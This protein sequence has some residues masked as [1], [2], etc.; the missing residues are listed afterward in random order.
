MYFE[1]G[2]TH[3]GI[4]L[5]KASLN[6]AKYYIG[7]TEV[8]TIG[9]RAGEWAAAPVVQRHPVPIDI[10]LATLNAGTP[11][12]VNVAFDLPAMFIGNATIKKN[13]T[14]PL[15]EGV[16]YSIDRIWGR[17]VPL[18]GGQ[19]DGGSG[20]STGRFTIDSGW[21]IKK[22]WVILSSP[23]TNGLESCIIGAGFESEFANPGNPGNT[24][25]RWKV[26]RTWSVASSVWNS[27]VNNTADYSHQLDDVLQ[28]VHPAADVMLW[29]SGNLD[30]LITVASSNGSSSWCYIG[31]LERVRPK[32]EQAVISAMMGNN[33]F[34][35]PEEIG[36]VAST[37]SPGRVNGQNIGTVF[38]YD[39]AKFASSA[40]T[41]Q[42]NCNY[43]SRE[44]NNPT[45]GYTPSELIVGTIPAGGYPNRYFELHDVVAG[46]DISV[47][48]NV[49]NVIY[50]RWYSVKAALVHYPSS[51]LQL[52]YL[53]ANYRLLG[54]GHRSDKYIAM[55][56][57]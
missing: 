37:S 49:S 32:A 20:A 6:F 30:R 38:C 19:F 3:G 21:E 29:F 24:G 39:K 26:Y 34:T 42:L 7:W 2:F 25:P 51:G 28:F 5:I 1:G 44:V 33:T 47:V 54:V 18:P 27:P 35:D 17:V 9:S 57:V 22:G 31:M 4:T 52:N 11:W 53:G 12:P 40:D 23:G 50:G 13:F 16:D 43:W 56:A 55:E 10:N 14:I 45:N 48:N 41:A 15:V 46:T 36:A 8:E